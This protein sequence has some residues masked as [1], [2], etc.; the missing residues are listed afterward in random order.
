MPFDRLKKRAEEFTPIQQSVGLGEAKAANTEARQAQ[1]PTGQRSSD[2]FSTRDYLTRNTQ[3]LDDSQVREPMG[4]YK[5]Q[6]REAGSKIR[7][8]ESKNFGQAMAAAQRPTSVNEAGAV[9]TYDKPGYK[10]DTKGRAAGVDLSGFDRATADLAQARRAAEAYRVGTDTVN[11]FDTSEQANL[12]GTAEG[13]QQMIQRQFAPQATRYT[14]G[15]GALDSALVERSGVDTRGL[16]SDVRSVYDTVE[17]E[18]ADIETARD[19]NI[20]AQ[21]DRLRQLMRDDS[22]IRAARDAA[23]QNL[24]NQQRRF[25][26]MQRIEEEDLAQQR[27]IVAREAAE[28]AAEFERNQQEERQRQ[29]EEKQRKQDGQRFLDSFLASSR[30]KRQEELRRNREAEERRRQEEA[31]QR[32]IEALRSRDFGFDF[33]NLQNLSLPNIGGMF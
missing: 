22:D 16:A 30:E 17:A 31:K 26:E 5:D 9:Y 6:T 4:V 23:Q 7:Q 28:R 10:Y 14:Q 24:F 21:Q 1:A 12:L 18:K 8:E 3:E 19:R 27:A 20:Q 29:E 33:G 13:R 11:H 32:Q 25:D 2:Q 15:M